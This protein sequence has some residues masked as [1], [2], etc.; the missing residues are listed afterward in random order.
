MATSGTI[1]GIN[2]LRVEVHGDNAYFYG[3]GDKLVYK[4]KVVNGFDNTGYTERFRLFASINK[5]AYLPVTYPTFNELYNPIT[6][7]TGVTGVTGPTGTIGLGWPYDIAKKLGGRTIHTVIG[8]SGTTGVIASTTY[9]Y[10]PYDLAIYNVSG[11]TGPLVWVP[12]VVYVQE[13]VN[14]YIEGL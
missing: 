13:K 5:D 2:Y 14:P 4:S 12:E 7:P 11:G 9:T 6:A 8:P 10:K 3:D 1:N